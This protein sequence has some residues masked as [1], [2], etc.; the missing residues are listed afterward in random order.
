MALWSYL[1]FAAVLIVLVIS[2]QAIHPVYLRFFDILFE[3]DSWWVGLGSPAI[4]S[5]WTN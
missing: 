3:E 5:W 1:Q 4:V 2:A